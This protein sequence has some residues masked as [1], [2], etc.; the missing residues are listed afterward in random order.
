MAV[1]DQPAK[2]EEQNQGCQGA[3]YH[4]VHQTVV[5]SEDVVFRIYHADTPAK[6]FHGAS[7]NFCTLEGLVEDIPFLIVEQESL[8]PL[9]TIHH[10]LGGLEY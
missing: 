4:V 5:G 2:E 10:G 6:L 8:Y 9:L 1:G 7:R 3:Y